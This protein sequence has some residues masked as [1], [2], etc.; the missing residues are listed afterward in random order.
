MQQEFHTSR[1]A[2][3]PPRSSLQTKWY[4]A[5]W[6]N[7]LTIST[8]WKSGKWQLYVRKVWF[9]GWLYADILMDTLV[10]PFQTKEHQKY[11]QWKSAKLQGETSTLKVI[12]RIT[13]QSFVCSMKLKIADTGYR[14][15]YKIIWGGSVV[16]TRKKV[17]AHILVRWKQKDN[18]SNSASYLV[19]WICNNIRCYFNLFFYG[20]L[21]SNMLLRTI[22]YLNIRSAINKGFG[23]YNLLQSCKNHIK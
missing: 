10:L 17:I 4:A 11:Q 20:L 3:R 1:N 9:N 18:L 21:W 23:N 5:N 13:G 6:P 19:G 7:E 12:K 16:S 14:Y 8:S 2:H 22:V 15:K